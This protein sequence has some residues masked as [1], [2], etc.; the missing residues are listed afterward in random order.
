MHIMYTPNIF[1]IVFYKIDTG[2]FYIETK[3]FPSTNIKF[4]SYNY[5][6]KK[7]A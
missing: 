5:L 2:F 1:F 6:H 4:H 7:G 3:V